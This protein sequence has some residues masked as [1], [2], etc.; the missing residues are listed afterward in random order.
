MNEC[1]RDRDPLALATREPHAP[2][3]EFDYALLKDETPFPL[4]LQLEQH[5]T[6][7]IARDLALRQPTFTLLRE[8]AVVEVSQDEDGVDVVIADPD[9]ATSARR[10]RYLIGCDGGPSITPEI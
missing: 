8:H 4:A 6:V 5:K 10:G 9:G 3:A 2:L 7:G 1:A